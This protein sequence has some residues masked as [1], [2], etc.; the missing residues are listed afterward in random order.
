MLNEPVILRV[1]RVVGY[2]KTEMNRDEKF[3][4]SSLVQSF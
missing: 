4:F 1:V 3:S 2:N